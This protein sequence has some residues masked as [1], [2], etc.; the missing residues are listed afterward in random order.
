MFADMWGTSIG[1]FKTPVHHEEL[2][3]SKRFLAVD[4]SLVNEII[5]G[6]V[7]DRTQGVSLIYGNYKNEN[8]LYVE[9]VFHDGINEDNTNFVEDDFDYGVAGR[10]EYR[11]FGDWKAYSDFT[12]MK[13]KEALLVIG[14]GADLSQSGDA[15]AIHATIDAQ[16]E[17]AGALGLYGALLLQTVE[18]GGDLDD[19][20]NYGG[21]V[22]AGYLLNP[23]CEVFGRYGIILFDDDQPTA[24]GGG[25]DTF[26]E[27]TVGFNYFLG[28]N[29]AAGHRAKFTVDLVYL[30]ESS[31]SIE[32]DGAGVLGDGDSEII[33]RAQFQLLI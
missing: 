23:S 31:P 27:L 14:A 25:E 20:T 10:A 5:G 17:T 32:S 21:L 12:A 9:V 29:G 22:Q 26:H 6:G 33:F 8:P 7:T 24:D 30:P 19:V 11:A 16:Y 28:D 2:S 13:N 1:Q 4:R 3:S 15:E 18:P